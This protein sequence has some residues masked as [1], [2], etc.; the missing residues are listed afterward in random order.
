M[1]IGLRHAAVLGAS[2]LALAACATTNTASKLPAT[3]SVKAAPILA[4]PDLPPAARLKRAVEFLGQG[5]EAHA[6]AELVQLLEDDPGNGIGRGLLRQIETDPKV[7]L[8]EKNYEY[9]V[10]PGETL[11]VLADRFLGDP[12]LFYALARYNHVVSPDAME[13]GQILLIPGTPKKAAPR[14]QTAKPAAASAGPRDPA[15]AAELRRAALAHMNRGAVDRAVP[16]LRQ[17]AK[18][19]PAST[20]IRRD[21]DRAVRIQASLRTTTP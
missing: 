8:G 20:P 10:K 7:M 18:A 4:T 11:S 15:R 16:L 12:L 3:S 19:D 9:R 2:A 21:L 17:A 14:T 13:A 6:K 5:Q 1:R